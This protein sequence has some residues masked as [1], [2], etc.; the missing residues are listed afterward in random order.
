MSVLVFISFFGFVLPALAFETLN[1]DCA[2]EYLPD[3]SVQLNAETNRRIRNAVANQHSCEPHR[4]EKAIATVIADPWIGNLETWADQ[5]GI[6]KCKVA[7]LDSVYRDFSFFDSPIGLMAGLK[8]VINIGGSYVGTDKISHFMTEGYEY[9]R[10]IKRG[11]SLRNILEQGVSEE[12]GIYGLLTTG[13]YSYAD[14]VANYRGYQFWSELINGENPYL[15]CVNNKWIQQRDFKW[16]HYIDDSFDE[17]INCN[18][19]QSAFM[20]KSVDQH[21]RELFTARGLPP[22]VCPVKPKSCEKLRANFQEFGV[23]EILLSDRCF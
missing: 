16:E 19:Y 12:K 9:Y 11:G 5:G 20:E 6:R 8:G 3:V 7:A 10:T 21:S 2:L 23:E 4:L 22:S 13:I 14:M 15:T 18:A 17:S 1:Y